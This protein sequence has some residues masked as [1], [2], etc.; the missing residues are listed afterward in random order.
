MSFIRGGLAAER[1]V[2]EVRQGNAQR[3]VAGPAVLTGEEEGAR[4]RQIQNLAPLLLAHAGKAFV[5]R[6]RD[7]AH[8]Y[9]AEVGRGEIERGK[10]AGLRSHGSRGD[11]VGS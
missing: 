2:G 4:P 11:R 8:R 10:R 5:A 1:E 6:H 9:G 7:Y 3:A